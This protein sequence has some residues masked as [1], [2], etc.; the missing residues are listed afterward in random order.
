MLAAH[1]TKISI[2][3]TVIRHLVIQFLQDTKHPCLLPWNILV[4]PYKGDETMSAVTEPA[5]APHINI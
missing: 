1:L 3:R 4:V 5:S 2:G